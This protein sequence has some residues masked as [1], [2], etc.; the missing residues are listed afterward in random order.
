MDRKLRSRR[1]VGMAR[2]PVFVACLTA[3]GSGDGTS[4]PSLSHAS[5]QSHV[6]AQVD[7]V[8]T[9][10]F[11][12]EYSDRVMVILSQINKMGTLVSASREV[13]RD[14]TISYHPAPRTYTSVNDRSAIYSRD[15]LKMLRQV[16]HAYFNRT[17]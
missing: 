8:R 1:A 9:E 16:Q 12:T 3:P 10:V 15:S 14:G 4:A 13:S 11:T 17:T 7:G 5:L 2:P 6:L